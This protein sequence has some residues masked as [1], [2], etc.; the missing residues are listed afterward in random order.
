MADRLDKL[1]ATLSELD[2]ELR[3]VDSLDDATREELAQAAAEIVLYAQICLLGVGVNEILGLGIAKG[4]KSKRQKARGVQV[5]LIKENGLGRRSN[6]A[7][8]GGGTAREALLVGRVVQQA[9]H[10][11]AGGTG[12]G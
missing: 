8:C 5:V 9:E 3:S 12:R 6:A 1:R 4:L 10:G 11:R 7:G 2:A